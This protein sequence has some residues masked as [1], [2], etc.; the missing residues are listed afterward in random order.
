M[1]VGVMGLDAG[2]PA[3]DPIA[4]GGAPMDDPGMGGG[5]APMGGPPQMNQMNK[6]GGKMPSF[7]KKMAP[8]AKPAFGAPA[9]PGK[10][11]PFG[12]KYAATFTKGSAPA[13]KPMSSDQKMKAKKDAHEKD[14]FG[15]K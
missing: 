9:V 12:N 4:G 11:N 13:G 15:K 6:K 14:G 5:S 10:D 2:A 1:V 3:G 8:G 7:G